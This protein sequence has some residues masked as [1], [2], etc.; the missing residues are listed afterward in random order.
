MLAT[1]G[2]ARC[3][4]MKPLEG[5]SLPSLQAH[6]HYLCPHNCSY[7]ASTCPVG[8]DSLL[9]GLTPIPCFLS[10]IKCLLVLNWPLAIS[11]QHESRWETWVVKAD[12]HLSLLSFLILVNWFEREREEGL[13]GEKEIMICSST[14][15]CL[16]WLIFVCALTR[17]KPATLA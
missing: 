6:V 1:T 16:H 15:V 17:T 2:E 4:H 8:Q 5:P 10:F 13:G 12:T 3:R 9:N 11:F 14:Y 7:M